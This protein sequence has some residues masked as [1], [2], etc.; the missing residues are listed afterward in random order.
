MRVT[1]SYCLPEAQSVVELEVGESCTVREALAQSGILDQHN[2]AAINTLK[3]GIFAN[4]CSLDTRLQAHDRVEI[5][6]DLLL[7][8]TEARKLR[9]KM[10]K[11]DSRRSSAE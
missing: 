9:A 10:Q 6:R 7:S 11:L 4:R 1:V 2:L 3:I 5:Y 8:P